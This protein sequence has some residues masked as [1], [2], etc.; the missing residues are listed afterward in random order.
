ME[1]VLKQNKYE[2][3]VLNSVRKSF[4]RQTL[5]SSNNCLTTWSHIPHPSLFIHPT[6]QNFD[7]CKRFRMMLGGHNGQRCSPWGKQSTRED[8]LAATSDVEMKLCTQFKGPF[9]TAQSAGTQQGLES[10]PWSNNC[11][12]PPAFVSLNKQNRNS[13][14]EDALAGVQFWASASRP[15]TCSLWRW[16][17]RAWRA[18]IP[19]G[20]TGQQQHS[21]WDCTAPGPGESH[22]QTML[23]RQGCGNLCWKLTKAFFFLLPCTAGVT[24]ST[25][26]C[27]WNPWAKPLLVSEQSS[28]VH[29]KAAT[30][31]ST[32]QKQKEVLWHSCSPALLSQLQG[33]EWQRNFRNWAGVLSLGK[34]TEI[35]EFAI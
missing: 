26:L 34:Y 11:N 21:Y 4:W 6:E 5:N 19:E 2:Q 25:R 14:D 22:Q 35:L 33:S 24:W 17:G 29:F 3:L 20:R 30:H 1:H 23:W 27:S 31:R 8:T 32:L 10:L 16:K 12:P 18:G 13:T 28:R 15:W 9:P 7:Q